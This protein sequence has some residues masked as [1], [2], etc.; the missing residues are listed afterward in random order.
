MYLKNKKIAV[1]GFSSRTG[2][3]LVK[4]LNNKGAKI[5]ISD[6]KNKKELD[7]LIKEIDGINCEFDFGGHSKKI[8]ESE[9]IVMSPGVPLNIPIL[10]QAK[11]LDIEIISEIELAYRFCRAK[12]IAVTGTNGKT[13]TVDLLGKML[14]GMDN[15]KVRT[16]GNIGIPL[17][18]VVDDLNKDDIIVVEVSS[19]QLA[20]VKEFR[21]WISIYL[22][23][24]PDHLDRH[25]NEE[26]YKNAKLKI[27][28]NQT[29]DDYALIDIDD[30]YLNS[31]RDNIPARTLYLSQNNKDA[32]LFIENTKL[33][34]KK[35]NREIEILD[36]RYMDLPGDHNKKNS[37]F[38]AAAAYLCGQNRTKIRNVL[39]NYSLKEHRME[40]IQNNSGFILVDDSKAT[41]PAAAVKAVE[42]FKQ[43][44]VLI[45]GGQDRNADFSELIDV[46]DKKVKFLI[47]LGETADQIYDLT[48]KKTSVAAV[49]VS[50]MQEA[51]V[52]AFK[53]MKEGDCLLLSPACPSWD[54][55]ENYKVR[56]NIFKKE[57]Q[58]ILNFK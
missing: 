11:L 51:V 16:A 13:T 46:I 53:K 19:F 12:I 20:A 50:D 38:A 33:M 9:L 34:L 2:I 57:V 15:K 14:Q 48:V 6:T 44:V 27:F 1:M 28:S 30:V 40:F 25:I 4:F 26:A 35:N 3:S 45:A 41:N 31:I 39:K 17:I 5:I 23:Y 10:N 7:N 52:T 49:K 32:D 56:G 18:S 47:L 8:L 29:K 43:P 21:P 24:S 54:M 42:S 37:A 58:N 55:Y 22:N 36:Y